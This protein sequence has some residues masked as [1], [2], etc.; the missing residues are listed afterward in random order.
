MAT[1]VA[2]QNKSATATVTVL[3]KIKDFKDL[4][5]KTSE[6]EGKELV[7]LPKAKRHIPSH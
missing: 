5:L 7:D 6:M 1:S 2:D 4:K 3:E